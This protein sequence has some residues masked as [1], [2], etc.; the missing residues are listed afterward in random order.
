MGR[1]RMSGSKRSKRKPQSKKSKKAAEESAEVASERKRRR[2]MWRIV[3]SKSDRRAAKRP[4]TIS[5]IRK[6]LKGLGAWILYWGQ[7]GSGKTTCAVESIFFNSYAK[8]PKKAKTNE[9]QTTPPTPAQSEAIEK[10]ALIGT[11]KL[12]VVSP[13][14]YQKM[15][16]S[17]R[18]LEECEE[19]IEF[20]NL[21]ATED[22]DDEGNLIDPDD[23]RDAD[24]MSWDDF[25]ITGEFSPIRSIGRGIALVEWLYVRQNMKV[26][27][28]L[29][30]G[31][32]VDQEF[33]NIWALGKITFVWDGWTQ[34]SRHFNGV[35]YETV[36]DLEIADRPAMSDYTWRNSNVA[37][38]WQKL[39]GLRANVVFCAE[40]IEIPSFGKSNANLPRV[41]VDEGRII[42]P[43]CY[44]KTPFRV[45]VTVYVSA[46][47]VE[48]KTVRRGLIQKN[49]FPPGIGDARYPS[50]PYPT[51]TRIMEQIQE[52]MFKTWGFTPTTPLQRP[53]KA[54]KAKK[55]KKKKKV[56]AE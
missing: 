23:G 41:V 45:H 42:V 49:S 1:G 15:A 31:T 40:S 6:K 8:R 56:A 46:E 28:T 54:K 3:P 36:L 13:E 32:L 11:D 12:I 24:P 5:Q 47:V 48:G 14:G 17:F 38:V 26:G 29:S 50:I 55:V 9:L 4:R 19:D 16:T 51:F 21:Y 27:D 34:S 20:Y 53:K 37:D 39:A 7:S 25:D 52:P 30:D 2:R 18:F 33:W 22:F 43:D 44:K 10:E 35:L